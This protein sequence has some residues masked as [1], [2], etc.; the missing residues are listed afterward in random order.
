MG[1]SVRSPVLGDL[2]LLGPP[3]SIGNQRP[4]ITR[5]APELA[6]DN[7]EILSSIGYTRAQIADLAQR[8]VV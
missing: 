5:T 8:G 6:Q 2:T 7:E 1:Q 3:V 4:R